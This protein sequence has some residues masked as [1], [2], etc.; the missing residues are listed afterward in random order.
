MEKAFRNFSL[1]GY[2]L[3]TPAKIYLIMEIVLNL[4]PLSLIV[5]EAIL[6]KLN[7]KSSDKVNNLIESISTAIIGAFIVNYVCSLGYDKI[8]VAYVGLMVVLNV[9]GMTLTEFVMR[10]NEFVKERKNAIKKLMD[11][12]KQ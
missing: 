2:K 10:S 5:P 6:K 12:Q 3:C 11:A 1:F 7:I 4:I 8:A 9:L